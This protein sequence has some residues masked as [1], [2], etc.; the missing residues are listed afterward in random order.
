MAKIGLLSDSHGRASTT[1]R[2]VRLLIGQDAQTIV[3]LGDVGTLEVLDAMVAKLD[4]AGKPVPAVH[5]VFGNC[6]WD[7][8][9]LADYAEHL[10]I[11]VDDPVGRLTIDGKTLVF[12]H[13]HQPAAMEQALAMQCDYL[14]HGHTHEQ[15]DERVGPTRIINPGALFRAMQYTVAVLD[16]ADDTLTFHTLARQ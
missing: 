4:G 5:V 1:Q 15:R 9:A 11:V 7:A 2:A 3:H 13:G 16:T 12:Q 14:C 10:G 8:P 6:D